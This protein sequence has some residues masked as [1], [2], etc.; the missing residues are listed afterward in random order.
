MIEAVLFWWS[1][2]SSPQASRVEDKYGLLYFTREIN[3]TRNCN[4]IGNY[5]PLYIGD[6]KVLQIVLSRYSWSP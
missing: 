5:S 3:A 1:Y 6:Q 2:E 4:I